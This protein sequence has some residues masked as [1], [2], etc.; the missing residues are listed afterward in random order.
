VRND[1]SAHEPD[2]VHAVVAPRRQEQ[3]DACEPDEHAEQCPRADALTPEHDAIDDHP[4]RDGREEQGCEPGRDVALGDRDD[5]V[6]AERKQEADQGARRERAPRDAHAPPAAAMHGQ[7]GE[8]DRAGAEEPQ[9]R[10][11]QRGD[12]LDHDA[13]RQVGRSPHDVDDEE[14]RPDLRPSG[15]TAPVHAR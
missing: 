1:P 11:Q 9:A 8:Q 2:H 13:D 3:G 4:Q 15:A 12:R 7:R 10:A 5:A 14:R 6:A